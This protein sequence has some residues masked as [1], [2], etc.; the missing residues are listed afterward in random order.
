MCV[1]I[2]VMLFLTFP[3]LGKFCSSFLINGKSAAVSCKQAISIGC[4]GKVELTKYLEM[5]S[6]TK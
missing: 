6:S 2:S 4:T 3:I 1:I 5:I